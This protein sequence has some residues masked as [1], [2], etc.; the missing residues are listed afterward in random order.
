MRRLGK[1]ILLLFALLTGASAFASAPA[2]MTI[3]V[4]NG[5]WGAASARDIESVLKSVAD[6][7]VPYFPRHAS[8]RVVVGF[9]TN[10]PRVLARK[11]TDDAHQVFLNVRDARWD[12]FAYQFSHEL[13]HI[14]SNYDERPINS[15]PGARE[16]QWFEETLCEAV[17]IVALRHLASSWRT[18]PP[19]A[20]W[21][22]YAPAFS[23]YAQRLLRESHRHLASADSITDWY[24]R[25]QAALETNP[26][27]RRENELLA[28]LLVE[29]LE[30]TPGSLEAIGY[31][32]LETPS[33]K[34]F[35]AYLV[36]WRDCC[37]ESHRR[38]VQQ[39]ISLFSNI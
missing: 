9:S 6:V 5:D 39:V 12:Q 11:L 25:H 22:D 18:S 29:L 33:E 19:H 26:Y 16:H 34:G 36:A 21:Q 17:S 32:N 24:M 27:L 14:F 23:D 2:G 4:L 35:A 28:T 13:C 37:P 30:S 10:G 31:L 1:V 3:E 15:K 20:G 8:A 38:F 7:L